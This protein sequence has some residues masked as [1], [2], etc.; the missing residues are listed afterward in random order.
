M[1]RKYAIIGTGAIGGFYGAKLQKSGL[2]IHFLLHNDYEYVQKHGLV[3]DSIDGNFSLPQI[4]AYNDV[5]KM[6]ICD[7]V[8][9]SLK[10]TQNHLLPHLLP[11]LIT[12]NSIVLVLQNGLNIEPMVAE[13]VGNQRVMG[14][15]CFICSQKVGPGHIRHLDYGAVTLGDYAA[16][17]QACG[18]TKRMEEIAQDFTNAGISSSLTPDLMLARWKKLVWNVPFNALSVVLNTT[19]DKIINNEY[20]YKLSAQL[21]Q[22]VVAAAAGCDRFIPNSFIQEMLDKT[23][24]M[25]PYSPSMKLDFEA[26]RPLEVEAILGNPLR[27]AQEVKVQVPKMEMLYQ[28][29][30]FIDVCMK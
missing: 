9:I 18:L 12:S 11:N 6:P 21:M 17:Y 3:I 15:L 13:I 23:V 16:N 22:E 10:T 28:Q 20:S 29:L 25:T 7:V 8:I 26:Q 4:N 14:G 24:K 2:D 19:T 27:V 1:S 5:G 30:K